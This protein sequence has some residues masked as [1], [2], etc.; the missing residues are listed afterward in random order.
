M[1]LTES[2]RFAAGEESSFSN[3][4][5]GAA[6][7]HSSSK[8]SLSLLQVFV[9]DGQGPEAPAALAHA[10]SQ[11]AGGKNL[12]AALAGLSE[13]E[14]Q[15][16]GRQVGPARL[17]EILALSEESDPRFFWE[18]VHRLALHQSQSGQLGVAGALF[19]MIAQGGEEVP[20]DIRQKAQGEWDAM[21]GK[22]HAG[23][24]IEFLQRQFVKQA[25]DAKMIAPMILG[26][27]VFQLTR[28]AALG[29]L[30][31]SAEAGWATRGF[32]A[33]FL[34]GMAGFAA[35]VPTFALGSRA[36]I[37]ATD[38]GVSW[39][40]ASVGRDLL[41]ATLTLGALK[42]FGYLG[43]QGFLR[44]HGIG[45]LQAGQLTR[46]Q[47]FT[48]VA[49]AQGAM[50][51][52]ML[53]AH[54]LEE[55]AGLRPHVD[56]AT[57]VTDT[58]STMLSLGVGSH[59]GH[60]VLG[61]RFAAFQR[62]LGLR[63][64]IY[65]QALDAA[66]RSGKSSPLQGLMGSPAL[67]GA[68][69]GRLPNGFAM[70]M[71][72]E[73]EGRGS[74]LGPLSMMMTGALDAAGGVP[75]QFL[76][77]RYVVIGNRGEPAVRGIGEAKKLGAIPVVF[78]SEADAAS[79]HANMD[80][81]I[82]LPLKGNTSNETYN[83][84]PARLA[85][86][87]KFM[88][89]RG[90]KPEHLVAWEG[91]GFKSED[92][93]LFARY[94]QMGLRA[95]GA[96][97]HIMAMMGNKISARAVA[98]RAG[99]PVVPGSDK[100]QSYDEALAFARQVGFPV[101]IKGGDTGGGKGIRVALTEAELPGAYEA[102][103][104]EA[105]STS[106]SDVV[107]MEKFIPSMRHLE[108]QVIGDAKGNFQVVGVR[109][110]TMQRNKQKVLEEDVSTFLD[111][112]MLNQAKQI[113]AKIM[114]QL[115]TD[116]PRGIGYEGPGTIELIWDR[117]DNRMYFMEMNTRLQ[118]EHT[119]TE[120]VSGQNLLREQLLIGSGRE[121]SFDKVHS[122]GHAIEARI[123]SEDPYNKF[124]PSTGRILHMRLPET[125]KDGRAVVRVDSG[126][127]V[128]R[129]IPSYYDSM[130]AKLIVHA[131][132]RAE[133]VEALRQ[134]L[135]EFEILGIKSN[136]PFL[137]A[138]TATPE[139]REGR[140]YD[141][142]FIERKFL[143][144]EA[145]KPVYREADEALVAA[146]VH[147]FL[148]NPSIYQKVELKFG[149]RELKAEVYET[150]PGRFLVRVGESAV[151]VGLIQTGD[152]LFTLEVGGRKVRTLIHGEPGKREVLIDGT[153]YEI[154]VGG[155]GA[156]GAE[157]VVSPAPAA[158]LKVLKG[159]GE[160]VKEG[161]PVLVTEAMKM[162]TTLT[163]AMDGTIESVF[164]KPGQQVDKGKAL[165]KIQP[166]GGAKPGDA[167]T[168]H[169]ASGLDLPPAAI[170]LVAESPSLSVPESLEALAWY[171]RYFEGFTGPTQT[172]KDILP[173]LEP[174]SEDGA[175]Y[176]QAVEAWA[177]GLLQR[178][179]AVEAVFQPAYQRHLGLFL[180][181]GK[182]ED[183]RF[184]GVLKGA[185]ALYGVESLESGAARD[186]A[187]K[188]LFRSHEQLE[189]KRDLLTTVL[190]WVSKHEMNSVQ[191]DLRGVQRVFADQTQTPFL[192][193]VETTLARLREKGDDREYQR[194][195]ET[196]FRS[197]AAKN[198]TERAK[199][200]RRLLERSE[201]ILP[202]LL[203][204]AG[205]ASPQESHLALRLI[206]QR[207]YRHYFNAGT[208]KE[209][210][211]ERTVVTRMEPK[212]AG[213]GRPLLVV[214]RRSLGLEDLEQDLH[215]ATHALRSFRGKS[216]NGAEG[217]VEVV[218]PKRP[219][220]EELETV[221]G[222][223]SRKLGGKGVQRLTLVIP[224][225]EGGDPDY[226]TYE[227]NA[228]G[229]FAENTL[230]RD[231]H[232]LHAETI[233]LS[234]WTKHFDLERQDFGLFHNVH[235]YRASQKGLAAN[236]P[237][238][239]R[240]HFVIGEHSG[241]LS[242][243]R[244]DGE[245]VRNQLI[246]DFRQVRS[247]TASGLSKESRLIWQWLPFALRESGQIAKD[248][249]PF[250]VGVLAAS[251]AEMIQQFQLDE[252]KLAKAASVYDGKAF[253]V[254]EA[255]RLAGNTALVM[256][257]LQESHAVDGEARK[258]PAL[259]DLFF[260][261]PIELSN[262]E[263]TLLAFRL[264]PQFMGQQLE[265]TVLHFNR[266]GPTGQI[267]SYIAEIKIPRGSRFEVNI[268]PVIEAPPHAVKTP[269]EHKR[270]QQQGRGK[271]Y[272][273][274][275]VALFHDVIKEFYPQGN[276]PE[277][278]V[279]VREL[280]LDKSGTLNPVVREPGQNDV[281]KVAFHVTLKLPA[282][283]GGAETVT[284]E[285]AVIADDFTFQAGSQGTREGEI[286]KALSRYAEEKGIP[287]LY[288]AETSGA[289]LGLA[290]EVAPFVRRDDAKG[291]NYV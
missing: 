157:F 45:E 233:G 53:S 279:Q 208:R 106:G 112:E 144:S 116:D 126:V 234:R 286:Y 159:V 183:P 23:R 268:K 19:G 290:E 5:R 79:L 96:A 155:E 215:R 289:R 224:D 212:A 137:R 160:S 107:F 72:G 194:V 178:Y 205:S 97:S 31:A 102:A 146:A 149:D 11:V 39:D 266:R 77:G 255:E 2:K 193:Q 122:Q 108:V 184:E 182:V 14:K 40:G 42:T 164:V 134:A 189:G 221:A 49:T 26:S 291:L 131:P 284:R 162:E 198:R 24:R 118:V 171:T 17:G 58:L 174:S 249:D 15:R 177:Q 151:E 252:V 163:A 85:A 127:E 276:L 28:T 210:T 133:A 251:P 188:R 225:L 33:R 259:A 1:S 176:R 21:L 57:A 124:A 59:L 90:L 180:K 7:R 285:F 168:S 120:M 61:S 114:A 70:A 277:D 246:Q 104:R 121:L 218:L 254:P 206:Q 6:V 30:A 172:L 243:R 103:K 99:V 204:K 34:S 226:R 179:Q 274:D 227:P 93:E 145:G 119:V 20:A 138:L 69:L 281:G 247:G 55:K 222:I 129:E 135:G 141:T 91:W 216:G 64:H 263:I 117:S 228:A 67:A 132:T 51:V 84:I 48:Q 288:L 209:S 71:T 27:A 153:S 89:E 237:K 232:P 195:L 94:E 143:N 43:N 35:E 37:S 16:L 287:K 261:Q 100:L 150:A 265:K 223:A 41:G 87:E 65:G 44:L 22:G 147:T 282:G 142:N 88:A 92:A 101:I 8:Y 62:E 185:L 240:R 190:G 257:R 25:T 207:L 199:A 196:D 95:A 109:D 32:G 271:L 244:F 220:V 219:G 217:V 156:L 81:V 270:V 74:P 203:G 46:F 3:P 272:V 130:I 267:E 73:G 52:G 125:P 245:H 83:N 280:T 250:N 136:I 68:G 66:P 197:A 262:E 275:R 248:F 13:I 229:V 169:T 278:A 111:P 110:C 191:G 241:K 175:P 80:G 113:G 213:R 165:V 211:S 166:A 63:A 154:G 200:V 187:V 148:K 283:E 47:R 230:L 236:D 173:K 239:D 4:V 264:T 9:T 273:Y 238:A 161:E 253:S 235:A 139:F 38:G 115:R 86:L 36:L 78:Y 167:A 76:S 82:A 260:R 158:V 105:F 123:T 29:R 231:I 170:R 54:K 181:N 50:F 256:R 152:H 186:A 56:G 140:N 202:F 10:A 18:G 242:Y 12:R 98:G 60:R 192:V 128:G 258:L 269:L 75:P 201:V 214:H